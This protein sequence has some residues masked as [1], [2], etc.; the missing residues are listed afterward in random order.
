MDAERGSLWRLVDLKMQVSSNFCK[1]I[2]SC[3]RAT[4]EAII[5]TSLNYLFLA[6]IKQRFGLRVKQWPRWC[7]ISRRHSLCCLSEF[8]DCGSWLSR[9]IVI[10]CTT[11]FSDCLLPYVQNWYLWNHILQ[12][13][14]F[15]KSLRSDFFF[16]HERSWSIAVCALF[17]TAR[18]FA[19]K[20]YWGCSRFFKQV[21]FVWMESAHRFHFL[22]WVVK[23]SLK[24]LVK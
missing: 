9:W 2:G 11:K 20:W 6:R 1:R 13:S 14:T 17:A 8:N 10:K 12:H 21:L 15:L 5:S 18:N 23:T 3:R 16:G 24:S 7:F 22:N 4:M 19:L